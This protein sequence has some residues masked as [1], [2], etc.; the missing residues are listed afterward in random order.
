MSETGI[1]IEA[2]IQGIKDGRLIA[3]PV[4]K[5]TEQAEQIAALQVNYNSLD[6]SYGKVIAEVRMLRKMKE[7][8]ED[9]QAATIDEQAEQIT[10]L[11]KALSMAMRMVEPDSPIDR[12]INTL[13]AAQPQG[14]V[15]DE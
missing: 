4:A 12:G 3:Y 11:K 14:E 13:L 5:L 9:N 2:A 8:N 7:H 1:D 6:E 15:E 10:R